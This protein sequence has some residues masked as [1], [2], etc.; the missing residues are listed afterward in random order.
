MRRSYSD[1][2]V[3]YASTPRMPSRRL[4]THSLVRV[5][6]ILDRIC[7]LLQGP[8]PRTPDHWKTPAD[9]WQALSKTLSKMR[10]NKNKRR[11][12]TLSQSE[13]KI[14]LQIPSNIRKSQNRHFAMN[15]RKW[16]ICWKRGLL[17]TPCFH[18]LHPK[19]VRQWEHSRKQW[20]RAQ[21]PPSPSI[22]AFKRGKKLRKKHGKTNINGEPLT[23]RVNT[24]KTT[25][26]SERCDTMMMLRNPCTR[27]CFMRF[28][29]WWTMIATKYIIFQ[30]CSPR[31]LL[32]ATKDILSS[33]IRIRYTFMEEDIQPGLVRSQI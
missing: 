9:I 6:H 10:E 23:R 15:N 32:L 11:E 8:C 26:S 5:Q 3:R 30:I 29:I 28:K 16:N 21:W 22:V 33:C 31:E 14:T 18:G 24:T 2:S 4:C 27:T 13:V 17:A 12:N 20:D 7:P 19:D 1:P 25:I